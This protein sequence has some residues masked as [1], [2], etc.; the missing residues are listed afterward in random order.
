MRISGKLTLGWSRLHF[1]AW[2]T[3]MDYVKHS[4][5]YSNQKMRDV[6]LNQ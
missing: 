3:V 6:W 1:G 2:S 5:S 4:G